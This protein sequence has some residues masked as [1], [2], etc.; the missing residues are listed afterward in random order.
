MRSQLTHILMNTVAIT[1]WA[2]REPGQIKLWSHRAYGVIGRS[3]ALNEIRVDLVNQYAII[4]R[5]LEDNYIYLERVTA[6]AVL[7]A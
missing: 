5:P 4:G 3:L 2:R 7:E 6:Y 1:G